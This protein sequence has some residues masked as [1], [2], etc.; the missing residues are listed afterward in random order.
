[1]VFG[2]GDVQQRLLEAKRHQDDSGD[3]RQMQVGVRIGGDPG[4]LDP[5]RGGQ[6]VLGDARDDVA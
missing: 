2:V 3:Q 5:G 4:P 1:V 6:P